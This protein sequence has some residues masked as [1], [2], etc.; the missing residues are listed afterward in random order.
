MNGTPN[1]AIPVVNWAVKLSPIPPTVAA[2]P[3]KEIAWAAIGA[4]PVARLL[5]TDSTSAEAEPEPEAADPVAA[6][7]ACNPAADDA[8]RGGSLCARARG[9]MVVL[10]FGAVAPVIRFMGRATLA[11]EP[12]E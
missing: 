11:L 1:D 2:P 9:A 6:V 5:A 10:R 4:L 12:S 8:C 7:D 3:G